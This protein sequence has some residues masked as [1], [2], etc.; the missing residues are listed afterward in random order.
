MIYLVKRIEEQMY[1]CEE[2]APDAEILVDVTLAGDDGEER[3]LPYS[4]ARLTADGI[5]EGD[6]VTLTADGVLKLI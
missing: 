6:T 2:P 3:V 4:D 1:G 5:D